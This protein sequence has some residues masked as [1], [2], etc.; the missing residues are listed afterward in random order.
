MEDYFEQQREQ[1]CTIH[2]LNNAMG[3]EVVT[4]DEVVNFIDE[5]VQEYKREKGEV[6]RGDEKAYRKRFSNKRT[7][8]FT[9]EIVWRAAQALG[10]VGPQIP[11][12]GFGGKFAKVKYL[13]EPVPKHMVLLGVEPK[14][15]HHAIAV[16]DGFI[17]DSL[18]PKPVPLTDEELNKSLRNVF[19]AYAIA[20]P[21]E[22][23]R[24]YSHL[25]PAYAFKL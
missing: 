17:Y 21:G 7:S 2:S 25:G 22:K 4:K 23:A 6:S 19:G 16:R 15:G 8:F 18:R 1:D 14:E 10:R 3:R 9:A 12:P 20:E 24:H 5:L 13:P 11:V